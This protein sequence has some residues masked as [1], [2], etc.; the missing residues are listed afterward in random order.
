MLGVI[1]GSPGLGTSLDW[2]AHV[3]QYAVV[4]TWFGGVLPP[5]RHWYAALAL[6]LLGLAI[7]LVQ[8]T[9][10]FRY[11]D[12]RDLAANT[13]G[14]IIGFLLARTV[15]RDWCRRVEVLLG[16]VGE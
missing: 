7:E 16:G 5:A 4:M 15:F 6:I 11:F 14:V 1:P 13:A 3:L 9:S 12:L 8:A 10:I 2:V